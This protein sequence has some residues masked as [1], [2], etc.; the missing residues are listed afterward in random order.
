MQD[1]GMPPQHLAISAEK[2][3]LR[4]SIAIGF[5]SLVPKLI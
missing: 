1:S 4:V 3:V 2:P 5:P